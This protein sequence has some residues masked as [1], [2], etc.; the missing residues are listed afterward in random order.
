MIALTAVVALLAFSCKSV[1]KEA[2]KVASVDESTLD[3]FIEKGDFKKANEIISHVLKGANLSKADEYI[4]NFEKDKMQRMLNE[5]TVTDEEALEYIKK[6]IPDVTEEQMEAQRGPVA[7]PRVSGGS[8]VLHVGPLCL[9]P[10]VT[11]LSL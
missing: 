10:T 8:R 5:F 7:N 3:Y 11:F 9:E 4:I 6:Y 2:V 1:D